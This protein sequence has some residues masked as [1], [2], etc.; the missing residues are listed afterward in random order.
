MQVRIAVNLTGNFS[1]LIFLNMSVDFE[2]C[3]NIVMTSLLL[4]LLNV[5]PISNQICD[6]CMSQDVW[7]DMEIYQVLVLMV[8]GRMAILRIDCMYNLLTIDVASV[9]VR[10][11]HAADYAIP[12]VAK[13]CFGHWVSAGV[14]KNIL[15]SRSILMLPQVLDEII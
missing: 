11:V 13:L 1:L 2:C 14:G 4:N 5:H 3:L 7:G 8:P 10:L 6:V 9:C 12:H 15:G